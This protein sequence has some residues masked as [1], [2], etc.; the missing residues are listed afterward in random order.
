MDD[1]LV[2]L[3]KLVDTQDRDDVL[4]LAIPLQDLLHLASHG[5]VTIADVLGIEDPAGPD[6]NPDLAGVDDSD[7]LLWAGRVVLNLWDPE[8]GYYNSSIY[9]NDKDILA[10]GLAGQLQ[11]SAL[12][13]DCG[14]GPG[15]PPVPPVGTC[16]D[17][18]D[19]GDFRAWNVD[20]LMQKH[21]GFGMVAFN[22]AYYDYDRDRKGTATNEGKA[23]FAV[24]SLLL[25]EK[26]GPGKWQG[27]LE[28]FVRFQEFDPRE[29]G[30]RDHTRW[31]F[32]LNYVLSGHNARITAQYSRDKGSTDDHSSKN[33]YK[34]GL[35][36][37]L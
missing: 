32:G 19:V 5:V 27:Q 21:L 4:Q 7:D 14:G 3:G 23:W 13:G 15:D 35:Q 37:Q 31:D 18:L 10:I 36:F 29:S 12:V 1:Q 34:L 17:A 28:P 22:G 26:Y 20:V 9:Y 30:I 16:T 8:P 25:P 2:I 11:N 6:T 33:I 24:G